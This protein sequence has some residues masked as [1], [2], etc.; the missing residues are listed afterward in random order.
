MRVV[1]ALGGNALLRR[2]E[3]ADAET[4][5]RNVALAVAALAEIAPANELIITHGNGPQ[6]GLLAL[7]AAAYSVTPPYPLDILGAESE[8]MVGYLL[9]QALGNALD[10]PVATVLTQILVAADDPAFAAPTKPIGPVYSRRDAEA[11]A[12]AKGWSIA[13]D[14]AHWRRVVPSPQPLQVIELRAIQLLIDAGVLVICAGG[15]G[16][17][18]VMDER[19]GL[20]G[21]EA[22][23]DKDAAAALLATRLDADLLMLLTDVDA[24]YRDWDT[25]AAQ[26]IPDLSV[27][28]AARMEF[29]PGSM[30]PK[31][32]A[33]AQFARACGRPAAIGA[34]T[35]AARIL[36][37]RAGTWVT[38]AAT[39][40]SAR[41]G[42]RGPSSHIRA[43]HA[44]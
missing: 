20:H 26:A 9:E 22:V 34:L 6:V 21:V 27:A 38:A 7:Q 42:S 2:G 33:A 14:G 39:G 15:G 28:E 16:I 32:R 19:G 37:R 30:E 11:V 41:R 1:V 8:G 23:I 25:S 40:T 3:A 12:A 5:R 29:A 36:E 10:Q 17:P 43:P 18:V 13:P 31:V 35:D 44:R 24:V 4:Q